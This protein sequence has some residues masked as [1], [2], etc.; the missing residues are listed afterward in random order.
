M[1]WL[2]VGLGDDLNSRVE[3]DSDPRCG[4]MDKQRNARDSKKERKRSSKIMPEKKQ[5]QR[6]RQE[7]KKKRRR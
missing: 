7:E 5:E 6:A 2:I 3:P 4:P 1:A